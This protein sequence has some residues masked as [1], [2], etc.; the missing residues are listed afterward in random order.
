MTKA[1]T[2]LIVGN[3]LTDEE[4]MALQASRRIELMRKQVQSKVKLNSPQQLVTERPNIQVA[5]TKL[6]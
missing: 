4:T 5:V 2:A 6:Q 1:R 3:S